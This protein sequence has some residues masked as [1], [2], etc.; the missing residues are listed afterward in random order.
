MTPEA[1]FKQVD[2]QLESLEKK[3]IFAPVFLPCVVKSPVHL[4]NV[5][6]SICLLV[7]GLFVCLLVQS[8][9]LTQ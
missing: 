2:F 3:V 4:H 8:S 1:F 9:Y 5:K 6:D 7:F